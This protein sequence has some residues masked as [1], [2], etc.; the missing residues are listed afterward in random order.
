ML[1]G[2]LAVVALGVAVAGV[3]LVVD[4]PRHL[5][6]LDLPVSRSAPAPDGPGVLA[7]ASTLLGGVPTAGELAS[8]ASVTVSGGVLAVRAGAATAEEAAVVAEAVG[9]VAARRLAPADR[10]AVVIGEARVTSPSPNPAAVLAGGLLPGLVVLG[11]HRRR[12]TG[13]GR[14]PRSSRDPVVIDARASRRRVEAA[15]AVAATVAEAAGPARV[16]AVV[17]DRARAVSAAVEIAVALAR[18][19]ERVLLVESGAATRRVADPSPGV[20]EVIAGVA[21]TDRAIRPWARGRIDVL[22]TG[23]SGPPLPEADVAAVLAPLREGY[24]R[25]VLDAPGPADAT[26]TVSGSVVTPA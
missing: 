11:A 1:R 14:L 23:R 25:I 9:T 16:L 7:D 15:S 24:D 10:P 26:F 21:E 19:G 6:A 20:R 22:P 18:A 5:A 3:L 12:P 2:V 4:P 17:D 8:S 13:L